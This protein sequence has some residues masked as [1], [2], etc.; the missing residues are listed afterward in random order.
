MHHD[1][2][3]YTIAVLSNVSSIDQAHVFSRLQ[4]AVLN[5]FY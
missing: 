3:E 5:D 4:R 2:P 1:D